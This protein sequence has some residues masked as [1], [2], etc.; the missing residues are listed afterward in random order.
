M[1]RF[2]STAE[3]VGVSAR[4]KTRG[5]SKDT[6]SSEVNYKA[7][8]KKK[9]IFSWTNS[10]SRDH[11]W[12]MLL[13]TKKKKEVS[14]DVHLKRRP[15]I[16]P[17]AQKVPSAGTFWES[18]LKLTIKYFLSK[19][20]DDTVLIASMTSI[21]KSLVRCHHHFKMI[22]HKIF[23]TPRHYDDKAQKLWLTTFSQ[24]SPSPTVL[25]EPAEHPSVCA[26]L[27]V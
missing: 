13:R 5:T 4:V 3:D 25:T 11:S 15:T 27:A 1:T 12:G 2:V 7:K 14:L 8:K 22:I 20:M 21:I 18:S 9:L 26:I 16:A 10:D 23:Q 17:R 6:G 19:L 24:M